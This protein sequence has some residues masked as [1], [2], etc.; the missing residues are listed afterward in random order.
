MQRMLRRCGLPIAVLGFAFFAAPVQTQPTVRAARATEEVRAIKTYG[1]SE[2][3]AVPILTRDVRLY[4]YHAFDGYAH[5]GVLRDWKVVRLENDLIEVFVLPEIGGKVWGARVKKTGHEFIY[6]NEVVKFRNIALRGP[7]TSGGIEF[8]FGVIG[9]APSTATPVDYVLRN[10]P[11]G[12]VSCIVGTMDLASRTEWRV[13]VRLPAGKGTFETNVLW[14]NPTPLEQ[15]YYNWMTA[16]AFAR[17]DL[18]LSIPGNAYLQHSGA[19][20][21]WPADPDGRVLPVYR[22]NTF[23]GNKSFHVVGEL[24]SFFGG[25]YRDAG[26][27]FGHWARHEEM[28]GQKLWLWALSRAGGIWED[29]LTDTD[30]QYVEYQAG[31]LLVQYSPGDHVN[32]ITQAGFDPL[33]TDRWTETWFPV[34]GIGGLTD[35]SPE[36]AIAIQETDGRLQIGIHAFGNTSDILRVWSAGRLVLEQPVTL[37][38]LEPISVSVDHAVGA[39]YRA[40]L[41]TLGIDHASDPSARTL[42]RPFER[43]A[44]AAAAMDEA[45]RLVVEARELIRARRHDAARPLLQSALASR[46]WHRHALLSMGD[47]E[48]RRARY[49]EGLTRVHRVMQLD[50]YDAEANFAAGNL[51]RALGRA[52]DARDAFGWAARS[53][54]YRS[55]AH[56]Q[57][58]EL[59]L[60]RQDWLEAGRYAEIALDY[61]RLNL[62]AWEIVAIVDRKAGDPAQVGTASA[63]LLELDPLHHFVRAEAWLAGRSPSTLATLLDGLRSEYPDQTL[64]ELAIA[65]ARRGLT[66]DAVALLDAVADRQRNPLLNLWAA[67][68]KQDPSALAPSADVA[69]VFPYR[70]E[71]LEALSWA[72]AH[73][74]HWTWTYLLALNLWALDRLPEATERLIPLG[75]TPTHPS[76]YVSRAFLVEKSGGDPEVDLTR[77][78]ALAGVSRTARIP[79]I[80]YYQRRG[81]WEAAA[82]A[83]AEALGLLGA[84][85]VLPSEHAGDSHRMFVQAHTLAAFTSLE[86]GRLDEAYAH[87][88]DARDWPEHLGQGRPYDPEERLLRFLMGRIDERRGRLAEAREHFDAVVRSSTADSA[89]LD[90]LD[91]LGIP[92]LRSLGLGDEVAHT[93]LARAVDTNTDAGVRLVAGALGSD[94]AIDSIAPLHPNQFGDLD[95][96]LLVRALSLPGR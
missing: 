41:Q 81:R 27:G 21:S 50:A 62:S 73:R 77:A 71:T 63:R 34:E 61:N 12:S 30:G 55:A 11:D 8:N 39:P 75:N 6:R 90:R 38:A 91:L 36:G 60:V 80:Q 23:G 64:L 33:A 93:I 95:G 40:Q 83:S 82:A 52:S 49:V 44:S 86:A 87:L 67:F 76:V 19:R 68:L 66:A 46:P 13:E 29:L 53:M 15:P 20:E 72:V 59:A 84:T 37:N 78:T 70:P 47:L 69:F 9:H 16:A 5:E 65:Y 96:A 22:N 43:D 32:P 2:P 1:Y 7:W 56:V 45:D 58:A 14:H 28:P 18:E 24:Q 92:A 17:E 85:R 79:L 10:N 3:N 25:Y 48:Y 94:A 54:A 88:A 42:S 89:P 51:Y 31:R 35:A 74:G 4:P 57:L 26:Y